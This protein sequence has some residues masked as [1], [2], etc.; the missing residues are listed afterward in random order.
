MEQHIPVDLG[1]RSYDVRI[2]SGLLSAVGSIVGEQGYSRA[3]VVTE[4]TV[5]PLYA[6]ALT[7]SLRAGGV[8]VF[9]VAF[10]AGEEHKTLAVA[11]TLIDGLLNRRP[12]VD[13]R[14]LVVALGGG[15]AGDMA[16]FVAAVTLRGLRWL[17]C[18][19][20]LLAD[21]DAST[22]GKTGVDH[23][24]GKNLI[25]SFHQ[26]AG[27]VI[28]VETLRTLPRAELANGMAE[29]VKHAVIRDAA[30]LDFLDEHAAAL[31]VSG[32]DRRLAFDG[33]L[34]VELIAR[35][36]SI[37]ASVVSADELESGIRA[38]LNYGHTIGHAVEAAAGY[39]AIRHGE[40]ISL[41]MAAENHIAVARGLLTAEEAQRIEDVLDSLQLPVR[42]EGLDPAEIWE[43]MQHDKKALGG[44]IRMVLPSAVGSVDIYDDLTENEVAG[45]VAFLRESGS[46]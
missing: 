28:D 37:K 18:P 42:K 39:G 45:A 46:S 11:S 27:V 41:G 26:P 34:M 10:P 2:G 15:V 5:S 30:L 21:V 40:A 36:V 7:E 3:A 24:A 1:D 14:T 9:T 13:R 23:A 20:S 12:P 38:H 35:N 8:E 31:T 33:D 22:G 25:G 43:I 29:C 6:A 19:T 17:Q 44:K 16:G 4:T 32:P